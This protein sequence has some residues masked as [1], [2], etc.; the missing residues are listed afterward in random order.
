[1][2]KGPPTHAS[3]KGDRDNIPLP[4]EGTPASLASRGMMVCRNVAFSNDR[5]DIGKSRGPY[6]TAIHRTPVPAGD[7]KPT[8]WAVAGLLPPPPCHEAEAQVREALLAEGLAEPWLAIEPKQAL[9]SIQKYLKGH[10]STYLS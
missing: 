8:S 4:F 7:L 3:C 2:W 9:V 5:R 6:S 10:Y 1:M